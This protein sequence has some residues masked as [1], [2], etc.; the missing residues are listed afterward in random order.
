MRTGPA[1]PV[2]T[3]TPPERRDQ[4]PIP[5]RRNVVLR[6]I[7]GYVTNKPTQ[8][9]ATIGRSARLGGNVVRYCIE[10][11]IALRLS[12]R[13][14]VEQM[15]KLLKVTALPALLMAVPIGA[16]VSV[17]VGG[18]M[19]QVGANSLAGAASGLGVVGQGAPMAAGLL[20]SG[21]AASAI[22]SDLGARAIREEIEA[23]RVMGIDP[24]QRLVVPR[25]LAMIA[26]APMLCII[27]IAAGVS[28]GLLI[29]ANVNDVVPGSFWQSFGAFAT[30]TDLAFSVLKS[31][32][33]A[34]MV[35]LIAGLRG[36]EAKGGPTGVANAVNASVVL[37]VFC[38]FAANLVVSQLQMMFFPARL[39]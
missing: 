34:A 14:V 11:T 27:I 4:E 18:I 37:S 10:D 32:I 36:L 24:V 12:V 38:I 20:M 7:G 2:E 8:S 29:S 31:V 33:F 13:E 25:F 16:E 15:W 26:I 39:A 9:L 6:K 28:A 35:V 5:W 1:L 3:E 21:A 30:P 17:Q 22:A 23:I 19:N